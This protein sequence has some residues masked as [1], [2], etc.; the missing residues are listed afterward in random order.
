MQTGNSDKLN[1]SLQDKLSFLFLL[2]DTFIS[3]KLHGKKYP[4]ILYFSPSDT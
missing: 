3:G 4:N 1:D 2:F